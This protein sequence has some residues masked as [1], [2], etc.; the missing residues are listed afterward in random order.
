[1]KK[2]KTIVNKNLPQK[3]SKQTNLEKKIKEIDLM[4]AMVKQNL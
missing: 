4:L 2:I 1:M 3:N